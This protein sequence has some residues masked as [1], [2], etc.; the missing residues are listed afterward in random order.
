MLGHE[1]RNP[2]APILTA[3][4]L[5]KLRPGEN[6]GREQVI[7]ERQAQHLLRL[8]DDLLDVSRIARGKVELRRAPTEVAAVLATALEIASP[9]FEDKGHR[10]ELDVA[11]GLWVDGDQARLSQVVANLLTNAAR[12]TPNGGSIEFLGQARARSDR[13]PRERQRH[14]HRAR[15]AAAHLRSVRSGAAAV[16]PRRGWASRWA[17]ACRWCAA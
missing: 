2:L 16:H 1:L 9:L 3:V 12:Y 15:A 4:E 17:S 13:H 7:I 8:V 11:E 14:R 6:T 5:L 10:L